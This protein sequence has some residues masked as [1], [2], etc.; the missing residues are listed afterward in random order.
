MGNQAG[1][2]EKNLESVSGT[3]TPEKPPV[4][5]KREAVEK[6]EQMAE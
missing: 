3:G 6:E 5:Q 1:L 2:K 4:R